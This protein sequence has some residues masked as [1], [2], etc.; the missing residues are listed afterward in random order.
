V[1]TRGTVFLV[2]DDE[3]LRRATTRLLGACG[4]AVRAFGSAEEFLAGYAT[5][6]E[7]CVLLD[8]CMPGQS[9]LDLQRTL[10]SRGDPLPIVFL[11]GHADAPIRAQA[12][13]HGAFEFLQKP[14]REDELIAALE[15]ALCGAD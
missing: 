2:D 6:D 1:S 12:L 13:K 4:F 5:G 15:R 10:E 11:S 14:V 3:A 7:G 9:G 8:V